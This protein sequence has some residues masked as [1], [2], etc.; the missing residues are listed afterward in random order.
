MKALQLENSQPFV[1]PFPKLAY[2]IGILLTILIAVITGL[3]WRAGLTLTLASAYMLLV[4]IRLEWGVYIIVAFT[5]LCIDGWAPNRSPEQVI[6]RL[7]VGHIYIMEFA[8]YG[9]LAIYVI[10]RLFESVRARDRRVFVPTAL[11]RPLKVFAALLPVFAV[12]GLV[13]GNSTKEALGYEEWRS[14]LIAIV[15]YF[16]I[17]SIFVT[18]EKALKLFWTFLGLDAAIGLYSLTMC[19]LGTDGPLPLVLGTGPVGEGPENYTFMFA[20]LC[21]IAWLLFCPDNHFWKRN[22]VRLA[23]IIPLLNVLL[24]QKRDPQ[25]GLVVGLLVLAW[26]VPTRR[27]VRLGGVIAAIGLSFLLFATV[28]GLGARNSGLER[29]TSRYAEIADFINNP[30]PMALIQSASPTDTLAFHI[31]DLVDSFNSFRLRPILGYGFGGHFQ[32]V[33][34][35]LVGGDAVEPGIVHDQYLDFCIKMGLVGLL[36]FLWVLARFVSFSIRSIARVPVFEYDAIALGFLSAMCADMVVEIWGP[37][38]RAQTKMPI[39]FLFS[40]AMAVC[41]LRGTELHEGVRTPYCA[42]GVRQG[43]QSA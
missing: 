8:V 17:T 35:S 32:R 30:K 19:L 1:L 37:S 11:D 3:N 34:T 14:L 24:S 2:C 5:V 41:L 23:A 9:L 27:K 42:S 26:K 20:A 22:L 29:S 13:L 15:L 21:A 31:F 40:L 4:S 39:V 6:F 25:L 10:R 36:G 28:L 12:Y 33:Y 16:L 18:R 38:W 7:S 43:K